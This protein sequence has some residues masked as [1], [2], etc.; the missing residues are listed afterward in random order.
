MKTRTALRRI[1]RI[2]IRRLPNVD[3]TSPTRALTD[4]AP[5]VPEI[6]IGVAWRVAAAPKTRVKRTM[7]VGNIAELPRP[8][9]AAPATANVSLDTINRTP[10][11]SSEEQT[12]INT[13]S[14]T[15][16]DTMDASPRPRTNNVK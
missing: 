3:E 11:T 9:T 16:R 7:F 4:A 14:D 5:S 13:F 2:P 15:L 12:E 6:N 8:A 1:A 10:T